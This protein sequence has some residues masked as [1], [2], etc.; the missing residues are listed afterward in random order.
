MIRYAQVWGA[1]PR[2][3]GKYWIQDCTNLVVMYGYVWYLAGSMWFFQQKP[4]MSCEDTTLFSSLQSVFHAF[5]FP[6]RNSS[7]SDFFLVTLLPEILDPSW[8]RIFNFA[9]V[10]EFINSLLFVWK[11]I[12]F[13]KLFSFNMSDFMYTHYLPIL[14]QLITIFLLYMCIVISFRIFL[15]NVYL[16]CLRSILKITKFISSR[17]C[18]TLA[19]DNQ[20][21]NPVMWLH[22]L[23][24]NKSLQR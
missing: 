23:S 1:W 10:L 16:I 8:R 19:L 3:V 4:V 20:L 21:F 18:T 13:S 12:N 14:Y 5:S 24:L 22:K 2:R 6:A 9:R 11:I 15:N 17:L 7:L